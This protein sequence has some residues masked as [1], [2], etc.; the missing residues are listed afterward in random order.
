[1]NTNTVTLDLVQSLKNRSFVLVT[2]EINSPHWQISLL[3]FKKR[4]FRTI[5]GLKT[6]T[7]AVQ[8]NRFIAVVDGG[9][10]EKVIVK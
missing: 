4:T 1:M 6:W 3:V 10:S 9:R 7:S 8:I 2:L 5:N